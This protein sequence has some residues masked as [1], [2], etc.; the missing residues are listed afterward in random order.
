MKSLFCCTCGEK[1]RDEVLTLVRIVTGLVFLYHGWD[2]VFVRGMDGVTGF[3]GNVGIP[4][5]ELMAYLVS[6]G[7]LLGGAALILGALTHWVAKINILIMLGAIFFVHWKDGFG[8]YE[9]QLLLLVVNILFVVS[10]AT[11]YSL[12]KHIRRQCN[13]DTASS[14]PPKV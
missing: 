1:Y 10:P 13:M 12:D 5:P 14:I 4:M 8:G 3:F 11:K 2:K 7:E 6:Y 9:F